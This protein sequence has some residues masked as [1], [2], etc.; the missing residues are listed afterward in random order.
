MS[1]EGIRRHVA[2]HHECKV[3]VWFLIDDFDSDCEETTILSYLRGLI[4]HRLVWVMFK[5]RFVC[6]SFSVLCEFVAVFILKL[7]VFGV[8]WIVGSC[9][10]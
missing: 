6:A 10:K 1:V 9:V 7:N 5:D 8:M 4:E 3:I 2:R